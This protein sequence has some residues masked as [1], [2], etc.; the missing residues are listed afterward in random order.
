MTVIRKQLLRPT[1]IIPTD[2]SDTKSVGGDSTCST[3]TVTNV[4]QKC[5]WPSGYDDHDDEGDPPFTRTRI[6]PTATVS[7]FSS[8]STSSCSSS[9]RRRVVCFDENLNESHESA[10]M[11]TK[12]QAKDV[13]YTPHDVA[14]FKSVTKNMVREIVLADDYNK[15]QFSYKNMVRH[16]YEQCCKCPAETDANLLTKSEEEHLHQWTRIA[17]NR[18]GL[19]AWTIR[20]I[21]YDRI[22][23]RRDILHVVLEIQGMDCSSLITND[24]KAEIIRRECQEISRG[25]RLFARHLAR[26]SAAA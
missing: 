20:D 21:A 9:K 16:A 2:F 18:L 25:S 23:R 15:T 8:L 12:Q 6:T 3:F 17:T 4:P 10:G 1:M 13:W 26:V 5:R 22:C 11:I 19:D 24:D 7:F 14:S